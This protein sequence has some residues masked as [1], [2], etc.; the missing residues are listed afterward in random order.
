M[1][2]GDK[3]WRQLRGFFMFRIIFFSNSVASLMPLPEIQYALL[4][5]AMN[6]E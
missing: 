6:N 5:G 3:R 2:E 1:Y 4:S